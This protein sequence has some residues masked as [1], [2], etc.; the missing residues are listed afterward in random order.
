MEFAF[1]EEQ[2]MIR[3]SAE[4]FLQDNSTSGAVRA[5]MVTEAG[6]DPEL[7]KRICTDLYW[8]A[9]PV[10]EAYGGLGLG[11]VDLVILLEEMGR[12]LLCSPFYP[13]VCLGVNSLLAAASEA[14]KQQW[15]P[16]I[17]EGSLTAT[18]A[19]T[20]ENRWGADSVQCV[21]TAEGDG[22]VLSGT[23]KYVPDG[24]TAGLLIIAARQENTQD[25]EGISLFALPADTEGVKRRWTP[26]MDQ[27]RRQAEI[28]LD[29]VYVD[30]SALLGN[31]GQSG[32]KLQTIL[33]L[34][35][36]GVAAEQ[37][38]G[39]RQS[40][41]M[42]VDYTRERVQFGRTIASFQAIKHRAAD[43]M[44]QVECA[45]SAVYY[46]ACVAQEALFFNESND[47]VIALELPEAASL[48][49]AYCSDAFFHCA[50]E[51]IQLHGG[52]G[53]TWE[54]DP[55]LYFKRAKSTETFLGNSA[56]HRENIA[57]VIFADSGNNSF[58]KQG[59]LS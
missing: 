30:R 35:A 20:S 29:N 21:A 49:K 56:Y 7:W 23:L 8:Q 34:A 47:N 50:A 26:T 14:Q 4:S 59:S 37:C 19:Y 53:F 36:I 2:E 48:A 11:Y 13:T 12:R 1:T 9:L 55:H 5:A 24:H 51:S 3:N 54:Y 57:R 46:A 16:Q 25:N 15:L 10:P 6:Y 52:V 18:L 27:T 28:T 32:Q 45:R 31:E 39:A 43:M 44:V 41:D 33:Q 42:T 58:D 40:L 22:F 38:G 17:A